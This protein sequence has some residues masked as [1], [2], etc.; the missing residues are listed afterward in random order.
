MQSDESTVITAAGR[1]GGDLQH[2]C[3]EAEGMTG[4]ERVG[5]VY[6]CLILIPYR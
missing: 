6:L 5:S 2:L 1:G 4:T 3:K